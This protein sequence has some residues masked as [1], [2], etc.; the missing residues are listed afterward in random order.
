M[1]FAIGSRA[2]KR[3]GSW[4]PEEPFGWWE[5]Q[6]QVVTPRS[7]YFQQL[8]DRRGEAAVDAGALPAQ[9]EGRIWDALSAWT[10]EDR[11]QP[12]PLRD[13]PKDQPLVIGGIRHL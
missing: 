7:L 6:W 11:F 13:E 8:A 2:N 9:R 12:C 5:H 3:E 10:G 1:K 4:A